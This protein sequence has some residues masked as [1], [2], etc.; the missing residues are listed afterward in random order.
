MMSFRPD[1]NA[2]GGVAW[3]LYGYTAFFPAK[4]AYCMGFVPPTFR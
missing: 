1:I 2:C 4:P 3:R